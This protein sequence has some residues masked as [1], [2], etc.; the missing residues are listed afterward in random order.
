MALLLILVAAYAAQSVMLTN[1]LCKDALIRRDSFV[2][3]HPILFFATVDTEPSQR[4]WFLAEAEQDINRYCVRPSVVNSV[5]RA[6][7]S[8]PAL[9][10]TPTPTLAPP[11][12]RGQRMIERAQQGQ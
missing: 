2:A 11:T 5:M 4:F 9:A 10:P 6:L 7:P 3:N 12:T 8:G 1:Q